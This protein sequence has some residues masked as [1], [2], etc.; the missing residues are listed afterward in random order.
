MTILQQPM[1][2]VYFN[3]NNF[4]DLA[5]LFEYSHDTVLHALNNFNGA[6]K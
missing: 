5:K 6:T 2:S 3:H 1:Y 4:D